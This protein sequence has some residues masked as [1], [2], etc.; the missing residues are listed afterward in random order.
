M[1]YI[2]QGIPGSCYH[3]WCQDNGMHDVWAVGILI[4]WSLLSSAVVGPIRHKMLARVSQW[5]VQI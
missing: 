3:W 4:A 1:R 5:Y 2:I